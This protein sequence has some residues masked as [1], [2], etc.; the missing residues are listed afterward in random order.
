MTKCLLGILLCLVLPAILPADD[1]INGGFET[2]DFTGWTQGGGYWSTAFN[3]GSP[4]DYLPGGSRYDMTGNR[5]AIVGIG[6]DPISGLPMV[7]NGQYSARI[8]DSSPNYHV[9]VASQTVQNYS[10]P[11]I[12][13]E[14]AAVLQASHGIGDSD[15][16]ALKLT[17]DT[18]GDTLYAVSYD[19]A[20]TPGYFTYN[21]FGWFYS[22]WQVQALDV[23]ARQ[24]D[25]FTLTVLGSDC[26]YG[27]HGGYVYVDGFAPNV[28]PPSVPEP[29]GIMLLGT[30]AILVSAGLRKRFSRRA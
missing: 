15:Y 26:P 10:N 6:T 2:G 8:N 20:S 12:Y 5:S 7:Y 11:A 25:T 17:D 27:G 1:F 28:V 13:F 16:F 19:S 9:S 24:G 14:W 18:V 30:A 29:S 22:Q 4:T 3:P 21:G 23:S